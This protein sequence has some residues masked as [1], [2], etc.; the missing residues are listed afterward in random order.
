MTWSKA[1]EKLL[2]LIDNHLGRFS[3][4]SLMVKE[5]KAKADANRMIAQSERDAD[6][7]KKGKL[8]VIDANS[9]KH[10][11]IIEIK[12]Q[13]IVEN[14][15]PEQRVLARIAHQ[16]A[17]KDNNIQKIIAHAADKILNNPT[18]KLGDVDE[19]IVGRIFDEIQHISKEDLQQIWSG[20]LAKSIL[21]P[22]DVS[23]DLID[24]VRK[25]TNKRVE[26]IAYLGPLV[27][28]EQYIIRV[29]K[30]EEKKLDFWLDLQNLGLINGV[31][32]G[33][34]I[35]E[36]TSNIKEKFIASTL[37][38]DKIILFEQDDANTI[39]TYP[40]YYL[41]KLAQQVLNLGSYKPDYEYA[42][43]VAKKIK[44]DNPIVKVFIADITAKNIN[45]TSSSKNT[46]SYK[47]AEEINN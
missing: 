25:L 4:P 36:I 40:V 28:A 18:E 20:L 41:T 39:L 44:K 9:S 10:L 35:N 22:D 11:K 47:N 8:T 6:D 45:D 31:E 42:R 12:A 26:E 21:K 3:N 30:I 13:D 46:L 38:H 29:E 19:D 33:G 34:L 2:S 1:A 14:L 23:V 43:Q 24:F 5:A 32:G 15:S 37:Y 17:K 16:E 7:I 27:F